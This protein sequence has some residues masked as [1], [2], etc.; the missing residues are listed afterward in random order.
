[1]SM[2]PKDNRIARGLPNLYEV[3]P[4]P[5]SPNNHIGRSEPQFL[6][7][8]TQK[9]LFTGRSTETFHSIS[10]MST[11]EPGWPGGQVEEEWEP[12]VFFPATTKKT[13]QTKKK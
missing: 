6:E 2:G 7:L 5:T 11:L 9:K 1:M 12:P 10:M 8:F 4:L 13:T 3:K